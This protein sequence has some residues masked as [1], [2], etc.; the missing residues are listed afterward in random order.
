MAG[1]EEREDKTLIDKLKE[2]TK[3]ANKSNF[4]MMLRKV[5]KFALLGLVPFLKG[6]ILIAIIAVMIT[7]I[8]H[9][10]DL[11][12]SNSIV[13]CCFSCCYKGSCK[14]RRVRK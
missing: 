6:L 14:Y 1:N 13:R 3:K 9:I 12:G 8:T 4:K 7:A 10:L 5:F 11:E 2:K